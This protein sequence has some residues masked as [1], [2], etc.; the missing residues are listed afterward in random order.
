MEFKL[1]FVPGFSMVIGSGVVS[2]FSTRLTLYESRSSEQYLSVDENV[3]DVSA[4]TPTGILK[5][6]KFGPVM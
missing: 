2:T 3:K 1:N 5:L 4:V 6:S